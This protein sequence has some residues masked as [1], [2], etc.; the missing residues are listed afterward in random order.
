[1]I[2]ECETSLG[3]RE[4]GACGVAAMHPWVKG[5]VQGT[6]IIIKATAA[7]QYW[8]ICGSFCL[9]SSTQ[10]VLRLCL[11]SDQEDLICLKKNVV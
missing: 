8:G 6:E 3:G 4:C 2:T 1:M 7:V 5:D 11:L 10:F 9:L